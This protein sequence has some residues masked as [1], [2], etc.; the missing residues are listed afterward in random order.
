MTKNVRNEKTHF[1]HL[2]ISKG[3]KRERVIK[4]EGE[5]E[6]S[7]GKKIDGSQRGRRER[8][9]SKGEEIEF[10]KGKGRENYQR[11]R[12]ER[13]SSRFQQEFTIFMLIRFHCILLF[14]L[15]VLEEE[16]GLSKDDFTKL[17]AEH[18][19]VLIKYSFINSL[20]Y[21]DQLMCL[22]W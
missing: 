2:Q 18:E 9:I 20:R 21:I 7:N 10:L 1:Y 4:R 11:E 8:G 17:K 14:V 15:Q 5:R 22:I 16:H 6:F 19:Y 3:K 12:R 13:V